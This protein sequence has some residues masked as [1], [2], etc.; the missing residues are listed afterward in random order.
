MKTIFNIEEL[1]PEQDVVCTIDY[2]GVKSVDIVSIDKHIYSHYTDTKEGFE[3]YQY[4]RN[5]SGDYEPTGKT[6]D[7]IKEVRKYIEGLSITNI[8]TLIYSEPDEKGVS[9][10]QRFKT[11]KEVFNELENALKSNFSDDIIDYFSFDKY[12]NKLEDDFKGMV[13]IYIQSGTEAYRVYI[14]LIDIETKTNKSFANAKIWSFNDALEVS[15]F[16]TKLFV[17]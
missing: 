16:I 2:K 6:F 13:S 15:N 12:D 9:K 7:T 5:G 17:K 11:N 8:E 1:T 4:N 10:F 14:D 3:C